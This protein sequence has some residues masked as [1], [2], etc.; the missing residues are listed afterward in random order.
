M[1]RQGGLSLVEL[2]VA[3]ALA[4]LTVLVVLQVMGVFT[5]RQRTTGAG[6]DAEIAAAVG[7]HAIERELRMAG[8]GL[9]LPGGL[10]CNAGMNIYFDGR[11]I[12]DG[13]A[14][15]PVLVADGG[16]AP[17]SIRVLRS[18]APFGTAPA[19]IVR[20]MPAPSSILTVD[21]SAGLVAGDLFVAGGADGNKICTLMQMTQDA[22]PTGNG[23]DLQ[24]NSG[25][26]DY[27]PPNPGNVF[28]SAIRYDVGD[29]VFNL[30]PLG[31][32]TFAVMCGG[33]GVPAAG[34]SCDLVR[35]DTLA[36]PIA[37]TL[38][39][40]DSIATQ[41]FD[42]QAQYGVAPAAS[43]T[44]NQWVDATGGTWG[45]PDRNA[46]ARIKAVRIAI[47]TRG[48]RE[49]GIVSP[50]QLVLWDAGLPTE[51]SIALTNDQR[52]YRYRVQTTVVPLINVIWAG[53]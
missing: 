52:R 44:V 2:M 26:S 38:A 6:N 39:D 5:A 35:F 31:L 10:A 50:A 16:A 47:V 37:P 13:Q 41:V 18:A 34:N 33:G 51:R 25:L 23:W 45:A 53:V 14:F 7:L 15:A 48:Q 43:Q 12:R 20:S 24:H 19:T 3:V 36:A 21:G 4:M 32:R 1:K 27:N 46:I 49:P 30:G 22:Q 42:F 8:A 40:V 11:V 9:T 17:D 29:V 28:A